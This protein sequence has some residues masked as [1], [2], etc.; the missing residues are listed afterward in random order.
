MVAACPDL[1]EES[2]LVPGVYEGG[3]KV[4]E[5]SL[6]LVEYLTSEGGSG[7]GGGLFAQ[8]E[9]AAM[10]R[11]R[12][13]VLEVGVGDNVNNETM[14]AVCCLLSLL[15]CATAAHAAAAT[16]AHAVCLKGACFDGG[17]GAGAKSSRRCVSRFHGLVRSCTRWAFS[18]GPTTR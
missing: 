11:R 18:L 3:L 10:T 17:G 14:P 8:N 16:A 5:A 7:G 2:D 6:D 1:P 4:W 12:Q 13:S 9:A 15:S